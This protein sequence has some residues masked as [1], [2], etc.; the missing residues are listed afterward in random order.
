[1]NSNTLVGYDDNFNGWMATPNA[2]VNTT[3]NSLVVSGI[4]QNVSTSTSVS[5]LKSANINI[6]SYPILTANVNLTAGVAYGIRFYAQ[7]PNGTAYDV[8]WGG[9]PLDHRP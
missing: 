3:Q 7:Y 2:Q 1:M 5:L 4:F 9:S 8:W 6:T